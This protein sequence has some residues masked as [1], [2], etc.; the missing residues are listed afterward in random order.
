MYRIIRDKI[1]YINCILA[2]V[3]LMIVAVL[4]PQLLFTIQDHHIQSEIFL[5]ERSQM[6]MTTLNVGYPKVLRERLLRFVQGKNSE[7][8][9]YATATDCTVDA[10]CY[11]ILDNVLNREWVTFLNDMGILLYNYDV[12]SKSGYTIE[13]CKRYVIYDE[14]LENGVVFMA[15]YFVVSVNDEI[16]LKLLVDVEDDTLYQLQI[17]VDGMNLWEYYGY[18]DFDYFYTDM[19]SNLVLYWRYYYDSDNAI[20]AS[21][22]DYD[23]DYGEKMKKK[24]SAKG[25][26]AVSQDYPEYKSWMIEDGK[27]VI[28]NELVYDGDALNWEM[29]VQTDDEKQS[30]LI[31]MGISDIVEL[32]PEF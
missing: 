2:M 27:M 13:E 21:Y 11:S 1:T 28:K 22:E 17:Q 25:D 3:I 23:T 24:A 29:H 32:V 16:E 20:K 15:W 12:I 9:Y 6:D 31:N 4:G 10:E 18:T 8:Q 5:G 19:V 14:N 26:I 7:K 30:T